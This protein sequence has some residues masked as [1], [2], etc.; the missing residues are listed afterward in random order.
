MIS[1]EWRHAGDV[2]A[3]Q[4][5]QWPKKKKREIDRR[6]EKQQKLTDCDL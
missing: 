4:Q 2:Q 5:L 3:I 6:E 1:Q